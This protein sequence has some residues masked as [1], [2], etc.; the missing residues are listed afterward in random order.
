M[1]SLSWKGKQCAKRVWTDD[2]RLEVLHDGCKH[3]WRNGM[4]GTR[5]DIIIVSHKNYG[6]IEI[7]T[8]APGV[9]REA[10]RLYLNED[11]L[12]DLLDTSKFEESLLLAK[13]PFIRHRKVFDKVQLM[14]DLVKESKVN[15]ILNRLS[16][17]EYSS[18]T[19][20]F[21]VGFQFN[22]RDRDGVPRTLDQLL[23]ERPRHLKR[24]VSPHYQSLIAG[25]AEESC[26][27]I[28]A[29][30]ATILE[31]RRKAK[32]SEMKRG[33]EHKVLSA[34][35]RWKL[36]MLYMKLKRNT[37]PSNHDAVVWNK[38]QDVNFHDQD[39]MEAVKKALEEPLLLPEVAPLLKRRKTMTEI[40]GIVSSPKM[41]P[42]ASVYRQNAHHH[43]V[44]AS[45]PKASTSHTPTAKKEKRTATVV[46][47]PKSSLSGIHSLS[48][49]ICED[50]G[51]YGT[52][53]LAPEGPCL[54]ETSE[55]EELSVIPTP[56][57][58]PS[59]MTVAIAHEAT[60]KPKPDHEALVTK[61]G[62][63]SVPA[64]SPKAS[65]RRREWQPPVSAACSNTSEEAAN[66]TGVR[67]ST[68]KTV[69]G[70]PHTADMPGTACS[71]NAP[72]NLIT[73][74]HEREQRTGSP[75]AHRQRNHGGVVHTVSRVFGAL[76]F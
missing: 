8:Y 49:I 1:L 37:F 42:K 27:N 46:S 34:M 16:V 44:L 18:Q 14:S 36:P 11:L 69:V 75:A 64:K 15:Y 73:I 62:T 45:S 3:F 74:P 61:A 59:V 7:A 70:T 23:V 39:V 66:C 48:K 33:T 22:F 53:H 65:R 67:P 35:E 51:N 26:A 25:E 28:E 47:T 43:T 12:F 20:H 19:R 41:S 71:H 50:I 54:T 40:P 38:V 32:L 68:A 4:K 9:D 55:G 31:L 10:A 63:G 17:E 58:T 5:L 57:L 60:S 13:E 72:F 30:Q 24:L 2:D 56:S 21:K 52:V 6:L 76:R 29:D